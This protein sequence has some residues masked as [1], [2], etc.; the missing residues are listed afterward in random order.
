MRILFATNN[1]HKI[2]EIKSMTPSHI[3][4][5]SLADINYPHDIPETG[6]TLEENAMIKAHTIYNICRLPTFCR[7][8][9]TRN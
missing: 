1:D 9:R 6:D 5:L 8:H 3:T 2:R 7:R 4:L